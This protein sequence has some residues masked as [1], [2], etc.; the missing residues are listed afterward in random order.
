MYVYNVFTSWMIFCSSLFSRSSCLDF[1]SSL[2]LVDE[3][4]FRVS[5]CSDCH[6]P[7]VMRR[8]IWTATQ[9]SESLKHKNQARGVQRAEWIMHLQKTPDE[10]TFLVFAALL[11]KSLTL[12]WRLKNDRRSQFFKGF[13]RFLILAASLEPNAHCCAFPALP[14][15]SRQLKSGD[16]VVTF[17]VFPGI[18][19]GG[20]LSSV[21]NSALLFYLFQTNGHSCC[22]TCEMS[23][24][25]CAR[26]F[27]FP[28]T[29][30]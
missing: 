25:I 29:N 12:V 2:L 13:D 3:P 5:C 23:H 16:D 1:S 30:C 7:R 24:V 10:N 20:A 6:S 14:E 15:T 17:L 21:F 11:V 4:V 28:N 8:R 18:S 19:T 9:T 27:F 22:Q 26:G